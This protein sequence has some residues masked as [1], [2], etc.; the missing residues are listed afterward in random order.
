MTTQLHE[1]NIDY[2]LRLALEAEISRRELPF[3]VVLQAKVGGVGRADLLVRSPTRNVLVVENKVA[4]DAARDPKVHARARQYAA[5]LSAEFF[6][7]SNLRNTFLFRNRSGPLAMCL[8]HHW[9]VPPSSFGKVAAGLVD[10]I[11]GS[12]RFAPTVDAFVADYE[13]FFNRLVPLARRLVEEKLASDPSYA[14]AFA[15]KVTRMGLDPS[16]A[17]PAARDRAVGVVAQQASYVYL[18][19]VFFYELLLHHLDRLAVDHR[20]E[21]IADQSPKALERFDERLRSSFEELTRRY[22][23]KPVFTNDCVLRFDLRGEVPHLLASFAA[24]VRQYDLDAFDHDIV[25]RIWQR[26]IPPEQRKK[27]GQI[28]TPPSLARLACALAINAGNLR[29][30]DP[31]C[32]CGTFLK[33]AYQRLRSLKAARARTV[34]EDALHNEVLEQLWGV[35]VNAFPAHLTTI[36]LSFQHE[37]VNTNVV[38]V[39][40]GDFLRLEPLREYW[41]EGWSVEKG[42][43][44]KL[45]LPRKFEV[46]V[47]NPPYVRHE[48]LSDVDDFR[49]SIEA[50]ATFARGRS[51]RNRFAC[52]LSKRSDYYAYFV[53]AGTHKL[54]EGGWLCFVLPD[55]WM[56]V[57][58]GSRLKEFLLENYQV[59]AVV[60]FAGSVFPDVDV[61][62]VLL[63]AT[64]E[65][66]P[67]ARA[68]NHVRFLFL[69]KPLLVAEVA[70]L[71]S[72][73]TGAKRPGRYV[74]TI[75]RQ[76]ELDPNVGWT[77]FFN[78]EP[79]YEEIKG[80]P[81]AVTLGGG[82]VT[83]V[84]YGTK[85]AAVDFFFMTREEA[86]RR[87]LPREFL[88]PAIKSAR[89]VP[90]SLEITPENAPHVYLLVP[91]D[92]DVDQYPSL[93]A[94][95]EL[96]EARGIHRRRSLRGTS[97]LSEHA[98]DPSTTPWYSAPKPCFPDVV[99]KRHVHE[100][101]PFVAV[102]GRVLA[103]DGCKGI[104]VKDRRH[105]KVVMACL[106]STVTRLA[107]EVEGRAEGAGDLQLMK[108][109]LGRIP[110]LNPAKL[111]EEEKAKIEAAFD[112][113]A[114]VFSKGSDP[115][116]LAAAKRALD[117]AV[118]E[119][120]GTANGREELVKAVLRRTQLRRSR[121][122]TRE[123]TL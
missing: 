2:E 94:Y 80:H 58:Y 54:V 65:S 69:E 89:H 76:E 53:W 59:R 61:G 34:P 28:Y 85:C 101:A 93:K 97:S 92:V 90:P 81:L 108:R 82:E 102:K 41:S 18:N 109:E 22:D 106:H 66:R 47:G 20:L 12:A 29:V 55:K 32:G 23:F 122:A 107:L 104:V 73:V 111:G 103:S 42:K 26:V 30:L 79:A 116:A 70:S 86:E 96:G 36:N 27:M 91:P 1:A 21:T 110:I 78:P 14:E 46:I 56:D 51:S 45:I 25:A 16:P 99:C 15:A 120:L 13:A 121:Q 8:V 63:L 88:V 75:R 10:A 11:T 117:E 40:V 52:K 119:P 60:G 64:R 83:S 31:A 114:E 9:I 84:E 112:R 48:L 3:E 87:N 38:N 44:V 43:P 105:L 6:C 33:A 95:L 50:Y 68:K 19:Q 74:L 39:V 5:E 100:L 37:P 62:T 115:G 17:D 113:Y 67:R 49:R 4:D 77:N 35:E 72:R 71:L 57:G 98:R 24:R 118:L 7:V 123:A